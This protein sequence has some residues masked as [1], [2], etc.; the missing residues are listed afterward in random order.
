MDLVCNDKT[1]LLEDN[2]EFLKQ[3]TKGTNHKKKNSIK[4]NS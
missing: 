1:K 4:Q 3:N 2:T